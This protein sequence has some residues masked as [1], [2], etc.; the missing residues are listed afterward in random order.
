[1]SKI[2]YLSGEIMLYTIFKT[3]TVTMSLLLL[4]A[5]FAMALEKEPISSA[6]MA[7]DRPVNFKHRFPIHLTF[8][9][10]AEYEKLN[11]PRDAF[12]E[13]A[14]NVMPQLTTTQ[15]PSGL[16]QGIFCGN[17]TWDA[18]GHGSPQRTIDHGIDPS[19]GRW[20]VHVTWTTLKS[21]D[22]TD[23]NRNVHYNCYDWSVPGWTV[24]TDDW[25][26]MP[27]IEV[28]EQA[29]YAHVEVNS[30][31]NA[32]VFHHSDRAGASNY[33]RVARF[34]IPGMGIYTG[35]RLT[36][37]ASKECIWTR[38]AIGAR[39]APPSP[40]ETVD[41]YHTAALQSAP[42][43]AAPLALV[44]WRYLPDYLLWQGPV[45]MD[46]AMT[47][48][49]CVLANGERVIYAFT[50]P[51]EYGFGQNMYNNDLVYYESTQS[52][53][54]W[55]IN[56][57]PGTYPGEQ[58]W[59]HGYGF[60]CT[61]YVDSDPHRAFVDLCGG[62]DSEGRLH[63]LYNNP[64]YDEESHTV[65]VGPCEL[66]HWDE[67]TPGSNFRAVTS[68]QPPGGFVGGQEFYFSTVAQA[69]WGLPGYGEAND[70]SSGS[71]NRYIGK[72]SLGFG[73]GSTPCA[74]I[75]NLDFL[76]VVYTQ[77]GSQ[78]WYD[79]EDVSQN[80]YQN[81]NIWMSISRNGDVWAGGRCVTSSN[82]IIGGPPTRSPGC[83][84][85]SPYPEAHCESEHWA[86]TA[87]IVNDTI[88]IFYVGDLD[89]GG[90]AYD[91]GQWTVND[92]MYLPIIDDGVEHNPLCPYLS[93][94]IGVHITGDPNCEYHGDLQ[95]GLMN[96]ETLTIENLGI[97]ALNFDGDIDYISGPY[98]W[99][100]IDGNSSIPLTS[101]PH[102]GSPMQYTVEMDGTS[103][104]KGL[105]R[106]KIRIYHNEY[107]RPSPIGVP[108]NFLV[109]NSFIC[110][111][112]TAVTTPCVSLEVSNVGSW[113]RD[114]PEGGMWYY[115][116]W[117]SD[118]LF[119]PIHDASI[120]IADKTTTAAGPDTVV[121]RDIFSYAG[122]FNP[123]YRAL[124]EVKLHFDTPRNDS[125]A[126]ARLCTV[127]S[128]IG[129]SVRYI[130]PQDPDSCQYVHVMFKMYPFAYSDP[131]LL[132]G[133]AVDFDVDPSGS[134][135]VGGYIPN[136]SLA[137]QQGTDIVYDTTYAAE[138]PHD[139]TSIDTIYRTNTYAAGMT[140]L[141]CS[142]PRRVA[143]QSNRDYVW[144]QGGFEDEYIYQQMDS[145]GLTIW[146]NEDP[147][148]V[149][150]YAGD[151]HTVMTFDEIT[152][153][154]DPASLDGNHLF[155]FGLVSS[156]NALWGVPLDDY[157]RYGDYE[158]FVGDL[159]ET[160]K[161][162]WHDAFG[163]P[164]G[165]VF[166]YDDNQLIAHGYQVTPSGRFYFETTSTHRDGIDGWCCGCWL[167]IDQI[168]P[169]DSTVG[170]YLDDDCNGHLQFNDTPEGFYDITLRLEDFCHNQSDIIV[171]TVEVLKVCYCGDQPGD[172]DNSG[173]APNPL[174]VS[175][176]VALVY[177]Q[178]DFLFD[179]VATG[180]PYAN[181]DLDCGGG[182]PTP[183]DVSIL[184]AKVYK[185]Q[186]FLCQDRC[187]GY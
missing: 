136:W 38:G 132:V 163:W 182:A 124:E 164:D 140:Y 53:E 80:G 19:S 151:L 177:K 138:P 123:G 173:G 41:V 33:A 30:S 22:L 42:V 126:A 18:Q 24:S 87:S 28:G 111:S 106:A 26:G 178:Q 157:H 5:P 15:G 100:T 92:L 160:T 57:G 72:M 161:Q 59:E 105:Y 83:N 46:S 180:C 20:F 63:L 104:D 120:L 155:Q 165:M 3:A 93:P 2:T 131:D 21:Y 44:Y 141:S 1:M 169:P 118:S 114:N 112:G 14:P 43:D 147:L 9:E 89:A 16:F 13:T 150:P 32:I 145:V 74:A 84:G 10:A 143:I 90:I 17:T 187:A 109:A 58:A 37:Y 181:G 176:M 107:T 113:G 174:D 156:S 64:G 130:F 60:N 146:R 128:T 62:F 159:I 66:L 29:G 52:G 171:V 158:L 31:G 49:H 122:T 133:A 77:F 35:D 98:G 51:R 172:V 68:G 153:N 88:H 101:I 168:D 110:G 179:Y 47:P 25:G 34:S 54:D 154:E 40:Q 96:I 91:E 129:I 170:L 11:I 7:G 121:Y 39:E 8:E 152:L 36:D 102:L 186:D 103:L 149:P 55:I 166:H 148:V 125:V 61:D 67:N 127:D 139:I 134:F 76:Y 73:D 94:V 97:D 162:I 175:L 45:L 71:W 115:S 48:S 108:I 82:G 99:L 78:W 4:F 185:G 95:N 119:S 137:Y 144:P 23:Q 183:L 69:L 86:S 167:Y 56:N 12:G 27:L 117:D 142:E 65:S 116:E 79:K 184:V 70:G 50:K 135:D 6:D 75:T 81:G 85:T